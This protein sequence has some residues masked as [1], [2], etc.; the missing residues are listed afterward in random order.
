MRL[1]SKAT[2]GSPVHHWD[3]YYI[4]SFDGRTFTPDATPGTQVGANVKSHTALHVLDRELLRKQTGW[5]DDDF[6]VDALH[7]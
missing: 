4:G 1:P 2:P 5:R 6:N 7:T 3:E